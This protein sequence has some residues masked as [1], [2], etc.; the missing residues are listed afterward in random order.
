V[1]TAGRS[2]RPLLQAPT[3][4]AVFLDPRIVLH[5][6]IVSIAL[7]WAGLAAASLFQ[8]RNADQPEHP[9]LWQVVR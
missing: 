1:P 2:P 7:A 8:V 3:E 6:T 9:L 4:R 5:G